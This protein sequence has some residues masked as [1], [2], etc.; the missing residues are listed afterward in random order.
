LHQVGVIYETKV[1]YLFNYYSEFYHPS[2]KQVQYLTSST[3]QASLLIPNRIN[4]FM[5]LGTNCPTYKHVRL[6]G[7]WHISGS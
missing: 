5:D 7:K 4:K 2:Y 6:L 1:M 3:V